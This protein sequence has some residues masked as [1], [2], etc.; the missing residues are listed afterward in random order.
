MEEK[1]ELHNNFMREGCR[2]KRLLPKIMT[3]DVRDWM[4]DTLNRMADV[5][6]ENINLETELIMNQPVFVFQMKSQYVV[7]GLAKILIKCECLLFADEPRWEK[8]CVNNCEWSEI[9]PTCS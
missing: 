5:L 8:K 9:Y 1:L 7:S 6:E 3:V 2:S 4:I